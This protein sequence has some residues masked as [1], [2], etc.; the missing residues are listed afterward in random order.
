MAATVLRG[1]VSPQPQNFRWEF[2]PQRGYIYGYDYKGA[3]QSLMESLALSF[4]TLGLSTRLIFHQGDTASLEVEDPTQA[5]TIDTWQVVGNEESRDGWSHP[6][7]LASATLDQIALCK[8]HLNTPDTPD[9]AFADTGLSGLAAIVQREY[10]RQFT[11]QTDYRRGQYVLRHT[12]N[13]PSRW[14]ANVADLN[15]DYIYSTAEL[16]SETT[17]S[18]LWVYPLP[19]RLQYKISNIPAQS[20]V[21]NYLWGWLKSSTTESTAANNRVDLTTEYSLEQW[22]TD[23]YGVF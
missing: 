18:S 4:N 19:P 7:I 11:G 9:V 8:Q 15:V 12:T 2:D 13:A 17:N 1:S 10:S 22:S 14:T 3:S 21:A 16:L 23:R 6:A 20:A 5:Y